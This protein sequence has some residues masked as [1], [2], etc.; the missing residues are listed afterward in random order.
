VNRE[1]QLPGCKAG[2]GF[3]GESVERKSTVPVNVNPMQQ[4][5]LDTCMYSGTSSAHAKSWRDRETSAPVAG[6]LRVFYHLKSNG[7]E[8]LYLFG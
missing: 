2:P 5:F 6:D 8:S 4:M 3:V 7:G 1:L